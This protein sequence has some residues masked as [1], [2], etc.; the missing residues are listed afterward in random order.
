M[1]NFNFSILVTLFI[2]VTFSS[3]VNAEL[4]KWVNDE[5]KTHY[6]D[7]TPKVKKHNVIIPDVSPSQRAFDRNTENKPIILPYGMSSRK[8]LLS[9]G[10]YQW[11]Q[12]NQHRKKL[13]VYYLGQF[14]SSRG[15]IFAANLYTDHPRF[16]PNEHGIPD[17]IKVALK[18]L[19]YD[20]HISQIFDLQERIQSLNGLY[21]KA[22]LL[23]LDLHTCA[24]THSLRHTISP[25]KIP[26]S[27]FTK[28]R[29]SVS[30]RWQL[31]NDMNQPAVYE[32][33]TKGY[34]DNW[35]NNKKAFSTINQALEIA[36][37][38]LFS[39]HK[40]IDLITTTETKPKPDRVILK[41]EE[42]SWWQSVL[43]EMG[44]SIGQFMNNQYAMRAKVAGILSE[45][46]SL[47]VSSIEYYMINGDWPRIVQDLR[48]NDRLFES[49]K[50][51]SG[52][53]LDNDGSFTLQLRESV[54]GPSR[55][56]R[57]TPD[58]R[59][60]EQGSALGIDWE[61]S[62]NLSVEVLPEMCISM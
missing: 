12:N 17:V 53:K 56:L 49:H 19:G 60:Y 9:Q 34:Y 30:I 57:M 23:E 40:F 14:C 24:P 1:L 27:N 26:W 6:S 32:T 7:T 38:N 2:I 54:F 48:L 13:G 3:A 58:T 39:D 41:T 15:A 47:K 62:S 16:L 44:N 51:I 4:Y 20:G 28:N 46:S 8:I 22:E 10:I 33:I 36:V 35:D 45:A 52:I 43:P 11:K 59:S 31:I 42:E 37:N 21:L 55:I 61:C 25:K 50:L 18:K 5:G 29:A